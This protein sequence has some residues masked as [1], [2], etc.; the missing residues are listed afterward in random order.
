[1]NEKSSPTDGFDARYRVSRLAEGAQSQFSQSPFN[2]HSYFYMEFRNSESKLLNNE[3]LQNI[4]YNFTKYYQKLLLNLCM[5]NIERVSLQRV[6][7]SNYHK[8][9]RFP[10]KK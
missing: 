4:Y 6:E 3:K 1:M 5:L 2:L 8:C 10:S 7:H 9:N